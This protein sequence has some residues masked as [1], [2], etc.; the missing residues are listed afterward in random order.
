[1]RHQSWNKNVAGGRA[2]SGGGKK[3]LN[4]YLKTCFVFS[5]FLKLFLSV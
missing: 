3:K 5:Y 2:G 4:P 1:M